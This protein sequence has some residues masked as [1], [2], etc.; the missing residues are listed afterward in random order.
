MDEIT[1][2]CIK[3]T[4]GDLQE[5]LNETYDLLCDVISSSDSHDDKIDAISYSILCAL[6]GINHLFA[7]LYPF[8]DMKGRDE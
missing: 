2:K 1:K 3:S 7:L 5:L 4:M 6:G 8:I